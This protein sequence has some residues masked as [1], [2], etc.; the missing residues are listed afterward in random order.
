M[1]I[2]GTDIEVHE[3]MDEL[4]HAR[5]EHIVGVALRL[6]DGRLFQLAWP[7][8][9]CH[10]LHMLQQTLEHVGPHT[11]GFI[12]DRDRFVDRTE[13]ANL[14]RLTKQT[15]TREEWLYSEDLW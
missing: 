5:V 4:R 6:K 12:T 7:C 11:Q 15:V 9:H 2:P 14:A 10:I 1:K 13:G 8:R 3:R